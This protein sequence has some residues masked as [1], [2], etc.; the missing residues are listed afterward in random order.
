MAFPAI[1][2]DGATPPFSNLVAQ[3]ALPAPVFSFWLNRDPASKEGG[4]LVL[5]GVDPD[6][7]TGE[8]TWWAFGGE[9]QVWLV[10][11]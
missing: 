4:E 1:A 6:H 2:V 11:V 10:P 7:F 8:H 5:G 3:G 9:G